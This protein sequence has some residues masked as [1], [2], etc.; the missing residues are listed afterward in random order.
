[1][2]AIRTLSKRRTARAAATIVSVARPR[3]LITLRVTVT[4]L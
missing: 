4:L 2:S 3:A 1:M